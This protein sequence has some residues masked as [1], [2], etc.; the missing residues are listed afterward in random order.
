MTRQRVNITISPDLLRQLRELAE[1]E[2]RSFS[3][4]VSVLLERALDDGSAASEGGAGPWPNPGPNDTSGPHAAMRAQAAEGLASRGVEPN[5][6]SP[7][8]PG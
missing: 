2:R 4:Q 7:V 8:Q 1:E 6:S 5:P 3:A